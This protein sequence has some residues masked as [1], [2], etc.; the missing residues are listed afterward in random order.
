[1]VLADAI[2]LRTDPQVLIDVL[3]NGGDIVGS[4]A[5]RVAGLMAKGR[6]AKLSIDPLQAGKS[7]VGAHP[8]A[9]L[10]IF[11]DGA[12]DIAGDAMAVVACIKGLKFSF[13][14]IREEVESGVGGT[15]VYF[16]ADLGA[17]EIVGDS[18]VSGANPRNPDGSN[19]LDDRSNIGFARTEQI[20]RIVGGVLARGLRAAP[21]ID[22][23]QLDVKS[24]QRFSSPNTMTRPK[25]LPRW[26]RR[27]R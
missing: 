25:R 27:R 6:K 13:C 20:G 18:C 21:E 7:I 10:V 11:L 14:R 24:A 22:V 9:S 26:K 19:E 16:S 8:N 4:K 3:G 1:M 12:N 5:E 2:M 17:S 15:A 23:E